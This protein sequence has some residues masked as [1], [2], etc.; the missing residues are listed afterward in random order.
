MRKKDPDNN[1]HTPPLAKR[2]PF[3]YATANFFGWLATSSAMQHLC[4]TWSTGSGW[5]PKLRFEA[6]KIR[7][8]Q[9]LNI[10]RLRRFGSPTQLKK[11][12]KLFEVSANKKMWN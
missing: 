12:E 3:K 2:R 11:T 4:C 7:S 10:E 8:R 9:V 1:V 6:K 5:S